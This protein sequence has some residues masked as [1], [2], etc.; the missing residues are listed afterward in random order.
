MSPAAGALGLL[1]LIAL[2]ALRVPVAVAMGVVGAVGFGLLNG[3]D[4]AG[5][6]LGVVP[7]EAVMPYGLSVVPL[8][9]LMGAFAARAG[10]SASLYRGVNAFL[11]HY[12][13]GLALATI[14]ACAAFGAIC[15]SSLATAATMAR[16]ALPEMRRYGYRDSLA[17]GA[18]AAGGTL[19]VLIPP[20][21][22]LVIYALVT[23]QSIGALFAAALLPGLLG[24]VL[25]MAAVAVRLRLDPSAGPAGRRFGGRERLRAVAE[26]WPVFL[27]F[28]L[29]IGGIYLGWFSPTEAAAVGA[30]GALLLAWLRGGMTRGEAWAA[31]LET[32]R[33]TAMIFLILVGA[34]LFND[35][36]ETA[37]L[38]AALAGAV[39]GSGLPRY[40]VL[41]LLMLCY[42]VLGCFMDS[43]SMMLLTL[44][45]VFPLVTS[46]G[47]DP[48]WFGIL[49]VT[50]VEIGLITPPV[51][52][53]LFV[54]QSVDPELRLP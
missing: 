43:L 29:V 46:L 52:L 5:F 15:G 24:T 35:F 14:G 26:T 45:V 28:A 37:G 10:L 6:V 50:V 32:A 40:A 54:I 39:A 53:N 25:Y 33:T 17:A 4:A 9:V 2:L 44:P 7:L 22:I 11:G 1:A 19:G 13:G 34:A 48:V 8:F 23:E 30:A 12:R 36:L 38:P 20:S 16:V 47:F 42:L 41:V 27:L 21:V 49:L 51:G 31:V 18:V 3:W